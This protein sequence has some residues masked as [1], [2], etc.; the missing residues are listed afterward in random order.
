MPQNTQLAERIDE[1]KSHQPLH[2]VLITEQASRKAN[3]P[4][5]QQKENKPNRQAAGIQHDEPRK[6]H[7]LNRTDRPVSVAQD[8]SSEHFITQSRSDFKSDSD[9]RSL[10]RSNVRYRSS[11]RLEPIASICSGKSC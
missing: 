1:L 11:R 7:Q 10:V 6:F 9:F 3:S 5:I 8:N 4:L 2:E